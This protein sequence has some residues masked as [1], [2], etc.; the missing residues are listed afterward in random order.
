MDMTPRSHSE[1]TKYSVLFASAPGRKAQV[2]ADLVSLGK[3]TKCVLYKGKR[4]AIIG[5]YAPSASLAAYATLRCCGERQRE[6]GA[7]AN[8]PGYLCAGTVG[9]HPRS[10]I[11]RRA[12]FSGFGERGCGGRAHGAAGGKPPMGKTYNTCIDTL[13]LPNT[14]YRN[15]IETLIESWTIWTL[16]SPMHAR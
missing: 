8:H 14:Q 7:D 9:T 13:L 10:T 15:D 6:W 16:G 1:S 12:L 11:P 3:V 4:A 5:L 2:P